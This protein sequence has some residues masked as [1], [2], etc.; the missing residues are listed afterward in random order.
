[1]NTSVILAGESLIPPDGLTP[2]D[3]DMK[4]LREIVQ[5]TLPD[6]AKIP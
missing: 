5:D 4:A 3:D 6:E 1:M 2:Q